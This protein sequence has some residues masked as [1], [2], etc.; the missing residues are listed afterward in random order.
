MHAICCNRNN[1]LGLHGRS[2]TSFKIHVYHLHSLFFPPPTAA[3]VIELVPSV[4]VSVSLSGFVAC[5]LCTA[6]MVQGYTVDHRDALCTIKVYCA[7][8]RPFFIMYLITS[9]LCVRRPRQF[10]RDRHDS[11]TQC[12]P[13]SLS[14]MSTVCQYGKSTV[15]YEMQEVHQCWGVFILF[16]QLM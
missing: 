16:M 4:C 3:E 11:G 15:C 8:G 5:R 14:I 10:T 9:S 2:S 6:T 7:H 1:S 13:V 12:S